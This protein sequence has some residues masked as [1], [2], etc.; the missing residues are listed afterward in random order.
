MSEDSFGFL[1]PDDQRLLGA[2]A[3][4]AAYHR[5]DVLLAEGTQ[6][7]KLFLIRQGYVRIEHT[8]KGQG[9]AVARLGPGQVFGE[10]SFLE[11]TGATASVIAEDDVHAEI[12]DGAYLDTLLRSDPGFAARFYQSL[13]VAMAQRLRKTTHDWSLARAQQQAA[14]QRFH[15]D[16]TLQL[17]ERQ[18]PE[19]LVNGVVAFQRALHAVDRAL[20]DGQLDEEA[21]QARVNASCDHLRDLI[22]HFT[23]PAALV[24]IGYDDVLTFRTPAQLAQG[25]GI[26]VLRET[27]PLLMTSATMARCYKKPHGYPEDRET[28]ERIYEDEPEG[29]GRLGGYLDRWFLSNA[30]CQARRE[31]RRQIVSQLEKA[32]ATAGSSGPFRITSLACGSAEELFDFLGTSRTPVF[33]T[34]LDSDADALQATAGVARELGY[35]ELI[36]FVQVDALGLDRRTRLHVDRPTALDLRPGVVRLSRRRPG[37]AAARLDS[38]APAE[39]RGRGAGQPGPDAR[40]PGVLAAHSGMGSP[41]A[42]GKAPA[43]AGG[44]Q[45]VPR[46]SAGASRRGGWDIPGSPAAIDK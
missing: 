37:I 1:T 13:A 33:A 16:R 9:I 44:P 34:C 31:G 40:R 46:P 15:V 32:A 27:F 12:V 35:A 22:E 19:A 5:G 41:P 3:E 2:K 45:P 14:W 17:S 36:T 26:Y 30:V 11:G 20:A 24:E 39:G 4:Q 43:R 8:A 18:L 42:L 38:R 6:A 29:D 7:R 28:L 23:Q 25:V 21:A 10:M